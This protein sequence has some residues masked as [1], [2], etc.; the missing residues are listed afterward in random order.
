[1]MILR[2]YLD[3]AASYVAGHLKESPGFEVAGYA[4][5]GLTTGV[6]CIKDMYSS[7]NIKQGLTAAS[8]RVLRN[9]SLYFH[10]STGQDYFIPPAV[11]F[12]SAR[13]FSSLPSLD[14]K[15]EE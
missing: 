13:L 1:M 15:L 10:S 8:F 11:L 12:E 5:A 9:S 3:G 6:A 2:H 7:S 14:K 4:L